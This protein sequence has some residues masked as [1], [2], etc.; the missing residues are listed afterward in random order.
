MSAGTHGTTR[1]AVMLPVVLGFAAA[2][3]GFYWLLGSSAHPEAPRVP[4]MDISP[5]QELTDAGPVDLSGEFVAGDGEPGDSEGMWP[6]FRGLNRGAVCPAPVAL[7]E[8]WG[9]SGPPVLWSVALGEGYAGAAIREGR[10]YLLDYDQENHGDALRCLSLDDGREIW[11][12]WYAVSI[13]RNHGISRTVPA[14]TERHVV[15][16]GPKCHVLCVDA[17]TGEFRWGIDMVARYGTQIPAWYAGQCPLIDEGRLILAPTG[18]GALAIAVDLDSGETLWETPSPGRWKMSHASI[19]VLESVERKIYVVTAADGHMAGLAADNGEILWTARPWKLRIPVATPVDV[20]EGRLFCAGGYGVGSAMIQVA[21]AGD[22][23]EVRSLYQL[24]AREFGAAQHTPVM[25]QSH[26]YG[27]RPDGQLV[28]LSLDGETVWASG[29]NHT[30]GLGPF[31]IA[32]DRL[33][34][35]DDHGLLTMARATPRGFE[36]L[37]QAKVLDGPDAWG[38]MALVGGRL[39]LRDLTRMVCLDLAA[40]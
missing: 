17:K 4:G 21:G 37:A 29:P 7:S 25:Y 20:G 5:D 10:V 12:R 8:T 31:M 34:A 32:G 6:W 38:P 16:I 22:G 27:V 14:V 2:A 19:A 18:E 36:F 24:K 28:C 30:F 11:R 13:K 35:M 39:I 1:W 15:T 33:L 3:M 23:W 40:R 26:L 9:E